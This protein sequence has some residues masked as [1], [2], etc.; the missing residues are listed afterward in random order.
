MEGNVQGRS[1]L[2]ISMRESYR[3][4]NQKFLDRTVPCVPCFKDVF[5]FVAT[6]S[7]DTL[8]LNNTGSIS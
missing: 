8:C 7:I 4:I 5:E 1:D 2:K 6:D 3:Q